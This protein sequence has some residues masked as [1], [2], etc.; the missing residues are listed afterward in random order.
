M[1]YRLTSV[2]LACALLFAGCGKEHEPAPP[3]VQTGMTG[4]AGSQT[5]ETGTAASASQTRT[6]ASGAAADSQTAS[7]AQSTAAVT[8]APQTAAQQSS[9]AQASATSTAKQTTAS[10]AKTTVSQTSQPASAAEKQAAKAKCDSLLSALQTAQ[11][12]QK[13]AQQALSAA[14]S[15][16]QSAEKA[17]QDYNSAHKGDLDRY[18][19][20]SLG[21]FTF[22]GAKDAVNVLKTAKYAS[23][24]KIGTESDATSLANMAKAFDFMRECNQLRAN[25]GLKPL[26]VTDRL[27]AIAQSNL[28]WSDKNIQHSKQ[29]N[30]GE[31]L[32]WNYK[33]PFKG[34]YDDEKA[35]NGGHYLNIINETYVTTGFAV[36][37]AGRSG[38]YSV[39]H[40]QVFEFSADKTYTVDEYE[41]R[42]R[43]Y[44]DSISAI[45]KQLSSLKS[46]ADTAAQQTKTC[47]AALTKKQAAVRQAEAAYN[48][49]KAAYDQL[50]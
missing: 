40:G 17:Y 30:V 2:L 8:T 39:S 15:K 43:S 12:E 1:K 7:A 32:S 4:I 3:P 27:M 31:N 29:F 50:G 5:A 48:A 11:A 14:Q 22:V 47:S 18:A 49:A 45:R 13:T 20:G 26:V 44:S 23:S 38:K 25:H 33:D 37:T 21:F 24:T 6:D 46:A 19:Q 42:F 28:N 36:C 34:W 35:T 10:A 9:A 16:Q 41:K